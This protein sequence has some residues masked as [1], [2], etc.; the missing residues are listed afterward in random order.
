MTAT[1]VGALLIADISGYTSF[2]A[3][4]ELEHSREIVGE[5]LHTVV[6]SLREPLEVSGLEGDAVFFVGEERPADL[7]GRLEQTF[8][9]FHSR[10]RDMELG[11]GCTCRACSTVGA[12]TLKFVVHEGRFARQ[13]VGGAE[14]VIGSDVIVVHRLLKNHVPSREYV[15]ATAPALARLGRAERFIAHAED[16][17]VGRVEGAYADLG[18]VWRA[19]RAA[20]RRDVGPDEAR[21][22]R[23]YE[24]DAPPEIAWRVLSEPALRRLVTLDTSID[25]EDGPRGALVGTRLHCH[26]GR[27]ET[28]VAVLDAVEPELLSVMIAR[29]GL[30]LYQ[31]TRL[32]PAAGGRTR[33]TDLYWWPRS[34]GF[35]GLLTRLALPRVL[36]RR[37]DGIVSRFRSVSADLAA[38]L[39]VTARLA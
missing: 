36:G 27:R 35:G 21:L 17:D 37:V 18:E 6:A 1:H 25:V 5:L 15:L 3:S 16:Y 28:V 34:P 11:I 33:C 38:G 32:E 8:V 26:H 19:A 30:T 31:T 13:R 22:R 20:E 12:L 4:T 23:E 24:V 14:Q 9:R 10:I 39:P 29:R 2:L 7:L